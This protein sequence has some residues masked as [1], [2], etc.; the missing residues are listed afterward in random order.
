MD[1]YHN[2]SLLIVNW[3]TG[4]KHI[5]I[6][7]RQEGNFLWG[8][9]SAGGG[10]EIPSWSKVGQDGKAALRWEQASLKAVDQAQSVG[11]Q[12]YSSYN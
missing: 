11:Q 8:R 3:Q 4:P 2:S 9:G 7:F 6:S 5:M 10:S 12:R 1:I